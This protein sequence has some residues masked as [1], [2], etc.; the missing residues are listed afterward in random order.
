MAALQKILSLDPSPL[1]QNPIEFASAG[2]LAPILSKNF[3]IDDEL[4]LRLER[5]GVRFATVS[6]NGKLLFQ[7]CTHFVLAGQLTISNDWGQ[8]K[9]VRFIFLNFKR[10]RSKRCLIHTWIKRAF[11]ITLDRKAYVFASRQLDR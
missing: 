6:Y 4:S 2:A 7:G 3:T 10:S 1:D 8:D 9:D 5:N 11:R